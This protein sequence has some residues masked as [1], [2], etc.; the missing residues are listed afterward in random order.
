MSLH[1][2]HKDNPDQLYYVDLIHGNTNIYHT[3]PVKPGETIPGTKQKMP[4]G[5]DH[6]DLNHAVTRTI[7]VTNPYTGKAETVQK[8]N[9]FRDAV[10]DN[11]TGLIQYTGW[12]TDGAID[13]A[14]Y[15][16]PDVQGYTPSQKD[17]A[18]LAPKVTDKDSLVA[19]NYSPDPQQTHVIYKDQE[20][21]IVKTDLVKGHTDST[22]GITITVPKNWVLDSKQNVPD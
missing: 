5:V 12:K 20:G 16:V 1:Y 18:K 19:V 9:F 10:V 2:D 6:D 11:V 14:A 21:N 4:N 15:T 13:F 8:V 7:V 3:K 17:V 22:A